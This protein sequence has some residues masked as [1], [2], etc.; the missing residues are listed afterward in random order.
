MSQR[1]CPY[2]R[3]KNTF[4]PAASGVAPN[5]ALCLAVVLNLIYQESASLRTAETNK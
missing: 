3:E 1:D 5:N 2:D 4:N